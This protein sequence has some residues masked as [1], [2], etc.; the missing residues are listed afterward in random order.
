MIT[1]RSKSFYKNTEEKGL[2]FGGLHLGLE[3]EQLI[4]DRPDEAPP[5]VQSPLEFARELHSKV[6]LL[7]SYH[8]QPELWY[9]MN[10][11]QLFGWDELLTIKYQWPQVL[12]SFLLMV[13]TVYVDC[14]VQVYIQLYPDNI[15]RPN[16]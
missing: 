5:S 10:C 11:K 4:P 14:L 15:A 6:S 3:T 7:N 13:L 8:V 12:F 2:F 9:P 16:C 1:S